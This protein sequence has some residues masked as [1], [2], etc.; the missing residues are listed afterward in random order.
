LAS[1]K[2]FD[3]SKEQVGFVKKYVEQLDNVGSHLIDEY[4]LNQVLI[5][6]AE[7]KDKLK[8]IRKFI[9]ETS[10]LNDAILNF[11]GTPSGSK[12]HVENIKELRDIVDLSF[13]KNLIEEPS[14][15]RMEKYISISRVSK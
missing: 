13:K 10:N 5:S 1:F 15:I 12:Y 8:I 11:I 4:T 14:F 9:L 3:F 7:Q 6:K 2:D